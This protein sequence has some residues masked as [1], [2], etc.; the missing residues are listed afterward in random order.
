MERRRSRAGAALA[1]AAALATSACIV[2]V[3]SGSIRVVNAIDVDGVAVDIVDLW[4]GPAGA[5]G[6]GTQIT[7]EVPIAPG[8][9]ASIVALDAGSYAVLAVDSYGYE[10]LRDGIVVQ[11]GVTTVI[12]LTAADVAMAGAP[13]TGELRVVN[14]IVWSDGYSDLVELH[15]DPADAAGFGGDVLGGATVPPE[16]IASVDGL[17]AGSYDVLGVD[18]DGLYFA[19]Y[20]VAVAGGQITQVTLTADDLEDQVALARSSPVS[21]GTGWLRVFHGVDYL[22]G[23]PYPLVQMFLAPA[24]VNTAAAWGEDLLPGPV[25]PGQ[26]ILFA[27]VSAGSWEVYAFDDAGNGYLRDDIEVFAGAETLVQLTSAHL[28]P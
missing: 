12:T 28:A 7:W 13:A 23:Q 1:A 26:S 22:D 17:A 8:G 2:A 9:E 24:P 18:Q 10:Y 4:V 16:G 20:G 19:L 3:S 6:F 5:T 15:V 27:D 14:G 21:P 25:D 11:A